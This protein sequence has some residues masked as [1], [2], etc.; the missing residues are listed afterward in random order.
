MFP[1]GATA[2]W[3]SVGAIA[4]LSVAL[5]MPIRFSIYSQLK[6]D[7]TLVLLV[8]RG[9]STVSLIII[10]VHLYFI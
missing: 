9:L 2:A 7:L 6:S 8:T 4:V 1:S 3:L 5:T 10:I